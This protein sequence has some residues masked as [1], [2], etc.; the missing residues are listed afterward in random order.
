MLDFFIV[1]P[2]KNRYFDLYY[3]QNVSIAF[4]NTKVF[5]DESRI[6]WYDEEHSIKEAYY[7]NKKRKK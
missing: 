6:E 4:C 2:I 3:H 1:I 7:E 5:F